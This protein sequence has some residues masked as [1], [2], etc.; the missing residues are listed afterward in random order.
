M[1]K[2]ILRY[3]DGAA[4]V[5]LLLM[6]LSCALVG[7]PAL[8]RLWPAPDSWWMAAIASAA[9][10]LALLAGI[11]TRAAALLLVAALAADLVTARGEI[12][13]LVLASGGAAGALV[14]LG[15]GAYSID[16]HRFGRRVIRLAPRSPNRGSDG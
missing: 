9:M 3:P 6:R 10:A 16:A 13:L 11:A 5:A 12:V 1:P 15:P 8:A 14:L 7:F 4:G 2:L